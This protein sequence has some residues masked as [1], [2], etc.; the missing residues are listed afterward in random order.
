MGVPDDEEELL[1]D[2]ELSDE[3]LLADDTGVLSGVSCLL[4][5]EE[6]TVGR[7]YEDERELVGSESLDE[8]DGVG[9]VSCG[10][11]VDKVLDSSISS[12]S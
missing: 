3:L 12:L 10:N 2:L 5:S 4:F 8:E 1:D 7:E 6:D 9:E 11:V